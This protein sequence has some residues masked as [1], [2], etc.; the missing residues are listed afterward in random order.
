MGRPVQ[1]DGRQ[2][3]QAILDSALQLFAENGYFGT[4]L[5]DIATRVGVRESALYNYFASKEALFNAILETA[6]ETKEERWVEFLARP[7]S[8]VRSVLED[9][10]ARVLDF[11]CEP[12]QQL[13]F[14]LLSSDGLRLARQ[15]RLDL[16][17]RSA[18]DAAPFD[19]LMRRLMAEGWLNAADPEL[20]VTEFIG[21]LLMWRR[22][23]AIDPAASIVVERNRFIRDHVTHFLKGAQATAAVRA[24]SAFPAAARPGTASK[25]SSAIPQ[26][27]TSAIKEHVR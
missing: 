14:L 15:G 3:R 22:C 12:R 4:S 6:Q 11:F 8:D 1:A 23:H 19:D 7:M 20:L 17:G 21:P 5:R 27:S 13:V 16:I 10:T 2:T 24:G 9:L 26:S 18:S 25:V